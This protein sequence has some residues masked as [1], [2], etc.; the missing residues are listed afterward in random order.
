MDK[1]SAEQVHEVLNEVPGVIRGLVER[2]TQLE[3]KVAAYEM[4]GRV[5]KLAGEMH[6]KGLDLDVPIETLADRLEKSAQEG[7][8]GE[9]EKAVA[10]VA[11]DMGTKMASVTGDEQ[12]SSLGSSDFERFLVGDV[13]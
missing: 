11:P 5:V 9:W 7:K 2:N 3:E 13:G 6:R 10:L 4:R 12:R 1:L 8:I